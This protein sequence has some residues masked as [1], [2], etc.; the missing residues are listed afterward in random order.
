MIRKEVEAK[1]NRSLLVIMATAMLWLAACSS[2]DR[3]YYTF[4]EDGDNNGRCGDYSDKPIEGVPATIIYTNG[5]TKSTKTNSQGKVSYSP[6][7]SESGVNLDLNYLLDTWNI[8]T[9]KYFEHPNGSMD[10]TP[11]ERCDTTDA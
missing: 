10:I 5:T 7:N 6:K 8:C 11:L 4:C 2:S 1:I 9:V 3:I